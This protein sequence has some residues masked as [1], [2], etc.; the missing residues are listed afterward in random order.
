MGSGN[1]AK[2][3]NLTKRAAHLYVA[4]LWPIKFVH[5]DDYVLFAIAEGR[6]TKYET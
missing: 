2:I 3:I 4:F 5:N 6:I 1:S